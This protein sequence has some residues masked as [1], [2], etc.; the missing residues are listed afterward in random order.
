[1]KISPIIWI[2][3][4]QAGQVSLYFGQARFVLPPV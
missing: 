1:M 3:L 2:A 4:S